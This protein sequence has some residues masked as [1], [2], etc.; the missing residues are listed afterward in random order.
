MLSQ[1]NVA[2][3]H[4][5]RLKEILTVKI[6]IR[7]NTRACLSTSAVLYVEQCEPLCEC[8]SKQYLLCMKLAT[9]GFYAYCL[10]ANAIVFNARF[11][12]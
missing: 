7:S 9:A 10:N 2:F 5:Q 12:E 1:F 8:V 4:L 6:Y 3:D 11:N